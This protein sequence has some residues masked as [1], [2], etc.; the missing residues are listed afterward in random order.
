MNPWIPRPLT[1]K[2]ISS[3]FLL[4]PEAMV[5]ELMDPDSGDWNIPLVELL[6]HPLDRDAILSLPLG[7]GAY[8]DLPIWHFST[9]GRF[10]VRSAYHV[11]LR[12]ISWGLILF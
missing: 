3:P 8:P 2:P 7:C 5:N 11:A 4:H 12:P 6:F 1:F 9:N 10:T